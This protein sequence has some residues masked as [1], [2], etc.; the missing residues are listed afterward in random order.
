MYKAIDAMTT[1]K[2]LMVTKATVEK[3]SDETPVISRMMNQEDNTTPGRTPPR[4]VS[5]MWTFSVFFR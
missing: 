4:I 3:P 5:R 1:T 2:T